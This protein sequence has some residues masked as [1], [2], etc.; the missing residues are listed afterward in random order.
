MTNASVLTGDTAGPVRRAART[1]NVRAPA[2][3]ATVLIVFVVI[4]IAIP[5][6]LV[7]RSLGA[8]G[9][10]AMVLGA[11]LLLWWAAARMVPGLGVDRKVNPVRWAV[12]LLAVALIAAYASGV[13][14]GVTGEG[15]RGADRGVIYLA[16]LS[17]IAL[18]A[19][20]GV[21]DRHRLD[22]VLKTLVLLSACSAFLAIL[23][24]FFG[25]YPVNHISIP[26]LSTSVPLTFSGTR[27]AVRRVS[28][29]AQHP[30]EFGLMMSVVL[31]LAFHYA[32]TVE[33]PH[34]RKWWIC[35]ILIA[36]AI[37]MS[38]SR[39]AIIGVAVAAIM[40]VPTWPRS[41]RLTLLIL[42][43]VY[44]AVLHLL[45]HGLFQT[46]GTLF[47]TASTDASITHRTLNY[48]RVGSVMHHHWLLGTGG[49][50]SY[51]PVRFDYVLD[52][53]YLGQLFET[54]VLGLGCLLLLFFVALW[55]ARG[56]RRRSV[57]RSDRSLAQSLAASVAVVIPAFF[58]FDAFAY[59]MAT[60]TVFLVI[61][62][63]GALWR[64][65]RE[66][67]AAAVLVFNP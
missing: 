10:P 38:V 67:Q 54:G 49:F 15:S 19:A 8:Q 28:G 32:T 13:L 58:T 61:G 33:R 59:P 64:L 24:F 60:G 29:T 11:A 37:P 3:A 1:S 45:V 34:N 12:G 39:A 35:T 22:R 51:D 16:A 20:D 50:G 40:L 66:E 23:S 7:L 14:H 62:C 44:V 63:C 56:A 31:P 6:Q 27:G 36:C 30:L 47:A 21:S 9:T 53:A 52:N 46:L 4:L 43:P 5:S 55:C 17:G 26:G 25:L 65:S 48:A 18:V 2:D 42:T 57:T 41:W